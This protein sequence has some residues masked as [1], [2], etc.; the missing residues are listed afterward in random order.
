MTVIVACQRDGLVVSDNMLTV[1]TEE[2][3][4]P[5]K[6][7][8][9]GDVADSRT[10]PY[11]GVIFGFCGNAFDAERMWRYVQTV[12]NLNELDPPDCADD[13]DMGGLIYVPHGHLKLD[14]GIYT[15][16]AQ[17]H[18]LPIY[19]DFYCVGG[20]ADFATGAMMN[21]A[22][23]EQAVRIACE[24]AQGCGLM[25]RAPTIMSIHGDG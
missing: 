7:R 19:K 18:P 8:R 11:A 14:E 15:F 20:G 25:G 9:F 10:H 16:N 13:D 4:D 24:V 23:A 22:T 6:L 5:H 17:M 1:G 21:G 3:Y 2:Y 12:R